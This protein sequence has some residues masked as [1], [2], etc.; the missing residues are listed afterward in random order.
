[1]WDHEAWAPT[2]GGRPGMNNPGNVITGFLAGLQP[3]AFSAR[4]PA[5][6]PSNF[7]NGSNAAPSYVTGAVTRRT[8]GTGRLRSARVLVHDVQSP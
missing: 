1:V 8:G 2:L 4:T 3:P 7:G 5:P 6:D